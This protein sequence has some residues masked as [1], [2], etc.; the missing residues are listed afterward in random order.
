M[1]L[2][3]VMLDSKQYALGG[4]PPPPKREVM[5]PETGQRKVPVGCQVGRSL[6]HWSRC[7]VTGSFSVTE[8]SRVRSVSSPLT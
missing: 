4:A 7:S 1:E 5:R 2:Y 8:D 6:V 3:E